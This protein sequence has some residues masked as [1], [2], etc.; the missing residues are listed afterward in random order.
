M[1]NMEK[2]DPN[3]R[4]DLYGRASAEEPNQIMEQ[5]EQEPQPDQQSAQREKEAKED[6]SF[7][8]IFLGYL[9]DITVILAVLLIAFSLLFRIVQVSGTSMNRT[10]YHGD[11]LLVLSNTFYKSPKQGDVIVASKKSFQNG[12]PIVKRVI[13]TEHQIVDIDFDKGIVYVDGVALEEPYTLEPTNLSEGI[14]FPL[15]VQDGC[16]FVMG[17]NRN[18]SK[19]SRS[20]QIGQIDKREVVGKVLLLI[21]PGVNKEESLIGRQPFDIS[22]IGVVN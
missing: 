1:D 2:P 9:H 7:Q 14:S 3:G 12:K 22:R 15:E 16:I 18:D 21:L 10:L 11:Y 17:D 4:E 6:N 20:P 5:P 8:G 13:A 19:D